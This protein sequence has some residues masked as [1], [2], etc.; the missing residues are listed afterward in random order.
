M[1][2]RNDCNPNHVVNVMYGKSL[3]ANWVQCSV[4]WYADGSKQA[5]REA[6]STTWRI[7]HNEWRSSI[8]VF[9]H[10]S[11]WAPGGR[12]STRRDGCVHRE[13][14][15]YDV[16]AEHG[17]IARAISSASNSAP[18]SLLRPRQCVR[19]RWNLPLPSPMRTVVAFA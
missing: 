4:Q 9:F 13:I 15:M 12:L 16:V 18:S 6:Y 3:Y 8:P 5:N 7:F 1:Y 17:R 11:N 19:C 10:H 14:V 2:H